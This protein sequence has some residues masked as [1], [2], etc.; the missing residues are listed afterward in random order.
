[1]EELNR[2]QIGEFTLN[3]S[4]KISDIQKDFSILQKYFISIEDFFSS[5]ESIILNNV[6]LKKFF[7]GVKLPFN[8]NDGNFKIYD[9]NGNFIGIGNLSNGNLKR[10]ILHKIENM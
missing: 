8:L 2:T 5:S 9:E 4:I 6:Q 7:N 10:K 3:Q 1:M